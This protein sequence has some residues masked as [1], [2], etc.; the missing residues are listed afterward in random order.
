MKTLRTASLDRLSVCHSVHTHTQL[1]FFFSFIPEAV[2]CSR[3]SDVNLAPLS[4]SLKHI[5]SGPACEQPLLSV[6]TYILNRDPA[7]MP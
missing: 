6:Y 7:A 1:F 5:D 2:D 4:F 3:R